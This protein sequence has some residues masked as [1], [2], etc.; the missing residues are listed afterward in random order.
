L[1]S[2][3]DG[4]LDTRRLIDL[5]RARG[6]RVYLPRITSFRQRRLCFAPLAARRST[7]R[8]GIPEPTGT[9]GIAAQHLD[10]I[11]APLVAFDDHGTRLGMGAG[12]Y[13]RALA[14]RRRRGAWRRPRIVGVA[15]SLQEV[16]HI[17]AAAHDVPLDAVITEGGTRFFG[18]PL[19]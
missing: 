3:I 12:F 17:A 16:P 6:C 7:N 2:P 15:F 4:E 18:G 19:A 14:F 11:L 9:V 8:Y 10:L 13:D 5:A 1:Y